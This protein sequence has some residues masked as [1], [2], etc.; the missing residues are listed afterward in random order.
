MAVFVYRYVSDGTTRGIGNVLVCVRGTVQTVLVRFHDLST[1]VVSS[2]RFNVL[3][4]NPS[5]P[6]IEVTTVSPPPRIEPTLFPPWYTG[7]T[8]TAHPPGYTGETPTPYPPDYTGPTPYVI[9]PG[10]TGETPTPYPPDYTG[11][12]P[13]VLPP[14]YTGETPTPY[15]PWYTG[16]TPTA[17][18]PSYT[19]PTPPSGELIV[20]FAKK[21]YGKVVRVLACSVLG[22]LPHVVTTEARWH[23]TRSYALLPVAV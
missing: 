14:G 4:C 15:P 12:T 7:E 10:Y 23:K 17:E 9:P 3:G 11:P 18:P 22:C 20:H 2:F 1:A 8:P 6:N 13:Y 19:G 16:E 21:D 5:K